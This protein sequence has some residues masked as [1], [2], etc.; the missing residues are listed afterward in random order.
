MNF[1]QIVAKYPDER[2]QAHLGL[3]YTIVVFAMGAIQRSTGFSKYMVL[4]F[5][6]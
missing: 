5:K 4:A 1:D 2:Y 3:L 6:Y